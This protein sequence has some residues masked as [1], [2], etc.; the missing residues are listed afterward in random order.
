MCSVACKRQVKSDDP[1]Y[2]LDPRFGGPEYETIGSMGSNLL[3][4]NIKAV[5]RANQLCN[6]A[7]IDNHKRRQHDRLHHGVP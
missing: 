2:P 4:G 7:G 1:E 3:N 6:L 5:A